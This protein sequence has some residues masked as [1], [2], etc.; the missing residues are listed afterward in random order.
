MVAWWQS[1]PPMSFGR[2][3]MAVALIASSGLALLLLWPRS[4]KG[5]G[6]R[7]TLS[8]L[9]LVWLALFGGMLVHH[10][11]IELLHIPY[12][13]Y[14][15]WY[16][17]PMHI[18]WMLAAALGVERIAEAVE[19]G[20]GRLGARSR[21]SIASGVLSRG[22]ALVCALVVTS[23]LGLLARRALLDVPPTLRSLRYDAAVALRDSTPP[24]TILAAANAGQLGFFS[25]RRC[26][27]LDGLVND[28]A[29]HRQVLAGDRSLLDYLRE[30]GV[31]Y[32]V[33]YVEL[34]G[35]EGLPVLR[36][37]GR[38]HR[39]RELRMWQ[40]GNSDGSAPVTGKP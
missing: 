12:A 6:R 39:G 4:A 33:D 7:G 8:A 1:L 15:D 20:A 30:T 37:F 3:P 35:L 17:A 26:V 13:S 16:R 9:H 24:E 19:A 22:I 29:Y 21:E 18:T 36:R 31:E 28:I 40:I 25:Q 2:L 32:V 23:C 38:D 11:L 27:N 5:D 10:G 34:P 14:F